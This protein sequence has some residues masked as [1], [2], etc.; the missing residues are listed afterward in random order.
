MVAAGFTL[1]VQVM[2]AVDVRVE[3]DKTFDFT[4]MR[5]WAWNPAGPGD[6]KMART[7]NDDPED[8]RQRAEPVIVDAVTSELARLGLR[9]AASP[10][11]VVTYYLLLTIGSSAQILGQFLPATT[12]WGVPPFAPA[13][14]SFEIMN[15][16]SLVLD[17]SSGGK[18]IWRGIADAGIKPGSDDKKA[19]EL[20]R[21]AVR[22]LLRKY[23][24]SK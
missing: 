18:V 13:T 11:L 24:R 17:L 15:R 12:M 2:N 4:A 8:I 5:T 23:P 16:G 1:A 20:I 7:Q 22:D 6:V 21:S 10:D 19:H 14:Q 3:H 9:P